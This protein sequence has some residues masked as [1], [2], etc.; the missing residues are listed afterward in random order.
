MN[1]EASYTDV[2]AAYY[3][4]LVFAKD[5]E[6]NHVEYQKVGLNRNSVAYV[7]L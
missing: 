6:E 4:I 5:T 2:V 3:N 7:K 1:R